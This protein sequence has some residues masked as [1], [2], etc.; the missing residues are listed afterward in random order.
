MKHSKGRRTPLT[1]LQRLAQ[2][3]EDYHLPSGPFS[4]AARAQSFND[5]QEFFHE[6]VREGKRVDEG[7]FDVRRRA[8]WVLEALAQ[9]GSMERGKTP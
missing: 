3:V 8:R 5:T 6:I 1:D 7:D 2:R 9:K 4:Y